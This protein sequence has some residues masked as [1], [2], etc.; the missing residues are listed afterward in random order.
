VN[1]KRTSKVRDDPDW[2]PTESVHP[3]VRTHP[4]SGRQ[5]LFVNPVYTQRFEG[6]TPEES[7]P[8]LE[9]L[10][11]HASRPEITCRFPWRTG[12][13]AFW[14]NRCTMHLAIHDVP[15][16]HRRMQRTQIAG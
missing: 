4:E 1:A 12:S 14:D 10:Y 5:C 13:I 3:V 15:G 8:L 7:A 6:M 2:H 16:Q 9:Y 11:R